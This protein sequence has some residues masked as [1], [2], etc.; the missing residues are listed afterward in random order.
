MTFAQHPHPLAAPAPSRPL[1][2]A[3]SR[4]YHHQHPHH[5]NYP[6]KS[7]SP[8]PSDLSS[9]PPYSLSAHHHH[10]PV[11]SSSAQSLYRF[12]SSHQ[13]ASN[14][15]SFTFM[16]HQTWGQNHH[17]AQPDTH[18]PL[19]P[20]SNYEHTVLSMNDYDDDDGDELSALPGSAMDIT[21]SGKSY[22]KVIRRR[23]SK[24][25]C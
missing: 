1:A 12:G 18:M 24:G 21:G 16:A 13:S 19:I 23:S 11:Q 14:L 22:E 3:D 7:E 25:S 20:Q 8:T 5:H 4:H 2:M 10:N 15:P 17:Y 9:H 6:L